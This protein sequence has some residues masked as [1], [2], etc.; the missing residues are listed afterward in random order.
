MQH[1]SK[2]LV[3]L[4][5]TAFASSVGAIEN[6]ISGSMYHSTFID[7]GNVY[8]MGKNLEGEVSES[9]EAKV[10]A[11]QFTG[12]KNAKSVA[13]TAFRTAV[14]TNAGTVQFSGRRMWNVAQTSKA[15]WSLP[16]TRVVSDIAVSQ[17]EF[18]YV[19]NGVLFRW[20]YVETSTPEAISTAAHGTVKAVAAGV[21]H[22][23]VLFTD[24]TVGTVGMNLKGQLGNGTVLPSST[25]VKLNV[26]N[27][28]N[29][30][31]GGARTYLTTAEGTVLA[32]G[33]NASGALG[34]GGTDITPR[35]VPTPVPNVANVLKVVPSAHSMGTTILLNNGAVLGGGWHNYIVGGIYNRSYEFVHLSN[36]SYT[37]DLGGGGQTVLL[38]Q[39]S[40]GV[41]SGWSGNSNGQLGNG[42]NI[43]THTLGSAVYAALPSS[44]VL[45]APEVVAT[46]PVVK[47][48]VQ[49]IENSPMCLAARNG[50]PF[51]KIDVNLAYT[52]GIPLYVSMNECIKEN[53]KV[54]QIG[55]FCN[56]L[57]VPANRGN[58]QV[59][60]VKAP[61]VVALAKAKK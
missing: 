40:S 29:V 6:K 28:K 31:A 53:R 52:C 60:S 26:S 51:A 10:F 30:A 56:R 41:I 57:I 5:G 4:I 24:G 12:F 11:P 58:G 45:P 34:M 22:A 13:T 50:S 23:V 19:V 25:L 1:R 2:L 38:T 39:G 59:A 7:A 37:M 61:V 14:L 48:P 8:A 43:E 35:L 46:A 16:E 54:Q 36:I 42:N 17:K 9:I 27:I 49:T 21:D 32:F 44:V 3:V 15:K 47:P 55:Q 18:Y 33:D 20:D